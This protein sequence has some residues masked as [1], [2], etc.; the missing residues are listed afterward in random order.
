MS[1]FNIKEELSKLPNKPG[2]YIMHKNDGEVIY[3]GKAK[4]LKNRVRQ[5]FNP[6]YK[7]TDKIELM[8]SNIDN[9]E[10]IVVDNELEALILESNFIKEYRPK[11]NTLLKDD[12]NYPYIKITTY[13]DFPRV[14]SVHRKS[15]D[16]AKY[17]GPYKSMGI[18]SNIFKFIKENY[19]IRLCKTLQKKEC[20]YYHLNMCLAPC[21]NKNIKDEYKNEILNIISLLSGDTKELINDL[22]KKMIEASNNEDFENAIIYRDKIN[23]INEINERQK[24]ENKNDNNKDI[25]GLYR[26]NNIAVI[27]IFEMRDGN[28]IDRNTNILNIDINDT[29]SEILESFIKQYYNQT[30]FLP[31][32]IWLPCEID[33]FE[34]INKWLNRDNKKVNLIV[35][36]IGDN[37]K[38]VKLASANAKIQY[39]QKIKKYL[40]ESENI[41]IAI[42]TLSKITG[43]NNIYRFESY[44][45]SNTAGNLN[46]ASMV[47]WE[48]NGFKKNE[49]RKFRIKNVTSMDDYSSMEEV[50]DRRLNRYINNDDKFINLPSIFL[51]DGGLGQVNIVKKVLKKYLIDIPVIGMVKDEHHN[52]RGLIYEDYEIDLKNYKEL[53]WL[54]SKIQDETHRFA[55]EYHKSIRSKEQVHSILD[56]I[57]GIG[58]KRKLALLKNYS[59]IDDLKNADPKDI[60]KID[61]FNIKIANEIINYLNRYL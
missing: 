7:K 34:I 46:V 33:E 20:L 19:R 15:D 4:N 27:Q 56:E 43:I 2:V 9:F 8:V 26:N 60:A 45:I 44:D 28:I 59:N 23:N 32:E 29:D 18:I 37:D 24:I 1:D 58:Q 38:L 13:E 30:Y 48:G 14:I 47:V 40:K 41:S 16:N 39:D 11:Y 3:V 42:D 49:Y 52:T 61:G 36:K 51:I 57:K 22:T 5:Y 55:I 31:N 12:K 10:Y 21:I 17:F 35:P 54:I 50:I 53:F 25:L 6:S